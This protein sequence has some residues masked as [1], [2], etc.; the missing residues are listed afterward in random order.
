M[1]APLTDIT[2]I[3]PAAVQPLMDHGF[4]TIESLADTTVEKLSA[5]SGFSSIRAQKTIDAAKQ[6]LAISDAGTTVS[7]KKCIL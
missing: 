3:G 1:A 6:L 7:V 4:K 2:G 5:V